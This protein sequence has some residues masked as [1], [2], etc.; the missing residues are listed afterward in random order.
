MIGNLLRWFRLEGTAQNSC[1]TCP[2]DVKSVG[3]SHLNPMKKNK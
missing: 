1:P 3:A 2:R